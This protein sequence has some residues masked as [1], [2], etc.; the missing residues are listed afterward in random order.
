MT[1]WRFTQHDKNTQSIQYT[2]KFS[3]HSWI[4][5]VS[6]TKLLTVSRFAPA[7]C[8]CLKSSLICKKMKLGNV[9]HASELKN[10][11]TSSGT[12]WKLDIA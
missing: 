12:G 5:K 3:Q 9:L 2:G 4:I 8:M 11:K 1:E 7:V 6:L 10:T